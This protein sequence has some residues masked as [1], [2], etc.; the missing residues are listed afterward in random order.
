MEF[1]P[2]KCQ[3]LRITNKIKPFFWTYKIHNIPI[4]LVD[5]AK[6]LGVVIDSKLT[7][8][9]QYSSINQKCSSSLAFIRR[10]LPPS[11]PRQVRERC[12]NTLVRPIA[13]YG[14]QVW[15]PHYNM[16]IQHL[17]KIQKRGARFV[18]RN[19]TMEAGNTKQNFNS[20][21]WSSL[22]ERRLQLKLS[23]FKKS[24]LKILDPPFKI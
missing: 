10:N 20:L 8:K 22:E 12:F 21:G 19:F 4:S 15:D 24:H 5:S 9:K 1:H 18:T 16:D 7:W 13:E 3:T 14:C 11:C 2:G 23:T 17:E 6:Y